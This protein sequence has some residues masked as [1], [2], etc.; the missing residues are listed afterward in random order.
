MQW[1]ERESLQM[2]IRPTFPMSRIQR[3]GDLPYSSQCDA[4]GT[5]PLSLLEAV[6]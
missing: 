4:V 6:V 5:P 3:P 2:D 1:K